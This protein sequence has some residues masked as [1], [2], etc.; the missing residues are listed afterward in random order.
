MSK[1]KNICYLIVAV[2]LFLVGWYANAYF[3]PPEVVTTEKIEYKTIKVPVEGE[4]TTKIQYVERQADDPAHIKL[5]A[6]SPQVIAEIN[7]KQFSFDTLLNEKYAFENG[8]LVVKQTNKTTIDM[9]QWA[10]K[11]LA[12]E[13]EKIKRQY[14]KPNTVSVSVL[15]GNEK[16]FVGIKYTG[17]RYGVGV[18]KQVF[19]NKKMVEVSATLIKW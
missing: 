2:I 16:P 9:S 10:N 13:R 14:D 7:G 6:E 8:Q 5:N 11:E 12:A 1:Y 3:K 17:R 15:A 19:K 4:T 18:Y